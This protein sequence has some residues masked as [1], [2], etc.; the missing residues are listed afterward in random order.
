MSNRLRHHHEPK[1]SRL[2]AVNGAQSGEG[3]Q[4]TDLELFAPHHSSRHPGKQRPASNSDLFSWAASHFTSGTLQRRRRIPAALLQP[5]DTAIGL[6]ASEAKAAAVFLF[7]SPEVRCF[8]ERI[9]ATAPYSLAASPS[10]ALPSWR[11][12]PVCHTSLLPLLRRLTR[13]VFRSAGCNSCLF[14]SPSP[15][16]SLQTFSGSVCG[17]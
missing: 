9:V 14:S 10:T 12:V 13:G 6:S 7:H 2:C 11:A 16:S 15:D 4:L 17:T 8:L 3:Q 5:D 1:R